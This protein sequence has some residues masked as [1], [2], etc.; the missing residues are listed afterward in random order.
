MIRPTILLVALA[1]APFAEAQSPYQP[2]RTSDGHPDFQG[3][4]ESR[5]MTPVERPPMAKSLVISAEQATAMV[6]AMTAG[7]KATPGNSNPDSDFDFATLAPVNGE[8][9]TSLI[10]EPADGKLPFTDEGRARRA[11]LAVQPADNP[12]ERPASE[13]CIGGAG[14]APMLT[15]PTNSYLRIIQAPGN[16]VL[17]SEA[18]DEV[19]ILPLAGKHGPDA[20]LDLQGDSIAWW[21]G[22]TLVVETL[23]FRRDDELRFTPPMSV[24]VISP[25]STITERFRRVS[26]NELNYRFT[27]TDPVLYTTPWTAETSFVRSNARMYEYA[28][29]EAN[30]ALA[31]ILL[32]A[33]MERQRAAARPKK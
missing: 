23:N 12:E 21:E 10:I 20:I 25:A 8:Y 33:R 32:G 19:R 30:Y 24:I 1:L 15:V 4:W 26:D 28:C 2:A 9:R 11:R 5:W 3:I 29:H 17:H 14:R 6:A 16:V 7:R 22:D 27:I 31:N 18:L 13:R